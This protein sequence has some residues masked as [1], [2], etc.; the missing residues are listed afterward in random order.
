VLRCCLAKGAR[1]L[2]LPL[3]HRL[4]LSFLALGLA[5]SRPGAVPDASTA[6]LAIITAYKLY[7][8]FYVFDTKFTMAST[9]SY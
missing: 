4:G 7:F 9:S 2:T 8:L 1:E 5:C 6:M 3:L